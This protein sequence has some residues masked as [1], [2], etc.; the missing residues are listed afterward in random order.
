MLRGAHG[1]KYRG[2]AT[3]NEIVGLLRKLPTKNAEAAF[4]ITDSATDEMLAKG[5]WQLV[6]N[7]E[8]HTASL[9]FEKLSIANRVDK[10]NSEGQNIIV[11]GMVANGSLLRPAKVNQI[12]GEHLPLPPNHSSSSSSS[13]SSSGGNS[14]FQIV[15]DENL[16]NNVLS[17]LFHSY[18][19]ADKLDIANQFLCEWLRCYIETG[20][21]TK[22]IT[23][24]VQMESAK[25][26]YR[27]L[28]TKEDDHQPRKQLDKNITSLFQLLRKLNGTDGKEESS[29]I[30]LQVWSTAVRMYSVR[31]AWT[32]CLHILNFVES[33]DCYNLGARATKE[34]STIDVSRRR[35]SLLENLLDFR[36]FIGSAGENA[37]EP[38]SSIS[39][40][41][42]SPG[43][44][45]ST[46][47]HHTIT[48]LCHGQ[49]FQ[50]ALQVLSHMKDMP[51]RVEVGLVT[52]VQLLHGLCCSSPSRNYSITPENIVQSRE[53]ALGLFED[54]VFTVQTLQEDKARVRLLLEAESDNSS[55]VGARSLSLSPVAMELAKAYLTVLCE[56][57]L[58]ATA[59]SFHSRLCVFKDS[60]N[61]TM[62]ANDGL[63]SILS[64][65][66]I[67][68]DSHR[69]D[70]I[71]S[72]DTYL[73]LR[74]VLPDQEASD[75]GHGDSAMREL[76]SSL[77]MRSYHAVCDAMLR[78]GEVDELVAFIDSTHS[79]DNMVKSNTEQEQ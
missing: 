10:S 42:G 46:L 32:H 54:V 35:L 41:S 60:S 29:K 71:T 16:V 53:L 19:V 15:Y 78:K 18:A 48:A 30:P 64:H 63:S 36:Y 39:Y 62:L 27:Q 5:M 8:Y 7:K 6:R 2:L 20:S 59:H 49:Q 70:W 43:C 1:V 21:K 57:G 31:R 52:S 45:Y 69:G 11:A 34:S 23:L 75:I 56:L 22:S 67:E 73:R 25:V 66:L 13:S 26:L 58:T 24:L 28:L 38:P 74:A 72:R 77:A 17:A 68:S 14:S 47:Y 40:T 4:H 65:I 79:M 3:V 33:S 37:E 12:W 50:S 9:A 51:I 76:V 61:P 55:T 44:C